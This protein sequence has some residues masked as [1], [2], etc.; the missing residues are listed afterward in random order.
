M[1][2]TRAADQLSDE[3]VRKVLSLWS[4]LDADQRAE[5]ARLLHVHFAEFN[6][7]IERCQRI[8]R[9]RSGN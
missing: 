9:R 1:T 5:Q 6:E 2:K 8:E 7:M 4:R 3:L